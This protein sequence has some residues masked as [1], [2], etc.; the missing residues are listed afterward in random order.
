MF[1][2]THNSTIHSPLN[3]WRQLSSFNS[4]NDCCLWTGSICNDACTLVTTTKQLTRKIPNNAQEHCCILMLPPVPNFCIIFYLL[5]GFVLTLISCTTAVK[6]LVNRLYFFQV[7]SFLYIQENYDEY[8]MVTVFH[9][10][11]SNEIF[12]EVIEMQSSVKQLLNGVKI[13]LPDNVYTRV[14]NT[15]VNK[16]IGRNI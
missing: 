5:I 13:K 8:N 3:I 16:T 1:F 12:I 4:I 10:A 2:F 6:N 15:Y 7:N 9:G 14:S 11:L